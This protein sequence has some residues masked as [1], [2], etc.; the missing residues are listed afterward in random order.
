MGE[1]NDRVYVNRICK[2]VTCAAHERA[3]DLDA[4]DRK[5]AEITQR[6]ITGAKIVDVDLDSKSAQF[7][8]DCERGVRDQDAFSNFDSE[9][10]GLDTGIEHDALYRGSKTGFA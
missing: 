3:I 1:R 10:R 2:V 8:H 9:K 6:R 7:S 4:I 5:F